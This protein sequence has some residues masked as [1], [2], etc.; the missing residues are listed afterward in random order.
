[1][2]MILARSL[3]LRLSTFLPSRKISP[4]TGFSEPLISPRVV[5]LPAPFRPRMV[6][7]SPAPIFK[8]TFSSLPAPFGS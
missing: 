2:A 3:L 5:D 4:E 7:I 8:F 1:M 6:K